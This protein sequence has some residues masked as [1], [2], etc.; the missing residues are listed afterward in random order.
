MKRWDTH[1]QHCLPIVSTAY[2]NYQVLWLNNSSIGDEGAVALGEALCA[3]ASLTSINLYRNKISQEGAGALAS[4]LKVKSKYGRVSRVSSATT[5][6][7]IA[8]RATR[9]ARHALR[10]IRLA[11]QCD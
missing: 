7:E 4:A 8:L 1:G 6:S 10:A 2:Y 3:N 5:V 11:R 9:L